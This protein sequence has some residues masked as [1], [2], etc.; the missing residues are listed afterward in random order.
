M[1][2]VLVGMVLIYLIAKGISSESERMVLVKQEEYD[3]SL[4]SLEYR[5]DLHKE[6]KRLLIN[7]ILELRKDLGDRK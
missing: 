1:I 4:K 5:I 3:K 2:S 6:E 7:S